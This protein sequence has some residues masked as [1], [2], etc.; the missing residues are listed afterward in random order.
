MLGSS[1]FLQD[2][3]EWTWR[4]CNVLRYDKERDMF[5]IHWQ[6]EPEEEPTAR[7]FVRR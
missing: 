4:S 6:G 3:L 7:K 5:L 2:D 1:L